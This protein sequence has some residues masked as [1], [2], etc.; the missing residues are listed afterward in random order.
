M[1]EPATITLRIPNPFSEGRNRV[2]VIPSDPVTLI[3]TGTGTDRAFDALVSQLGEHDI[4]IRDIGRV[5]LTHKHID[6]I[7]NAWRIQQESDAEILIHES[8]MKSIAD[9]DPDSVRFKD[10]VADRL[11]QWNVRDDVM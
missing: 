6:H 8:E 5:I 10:L 2:Y 3:D 7:G 9:V 4:S 1:T 11:T